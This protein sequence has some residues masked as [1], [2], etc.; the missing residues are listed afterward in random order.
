M[1]YVDVLITTEEDTE[2]VFQIKASEKGKPGEPQ[3]FTEVAAE[4]YREVA[5][6]LEEKFH[7]K[8]VAITLRENPLVWR[9]TWTPIVHAARQFYADLNHDL[10]IRP[11]PSPPPSFPLSFLLS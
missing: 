8:A 6:R 3:K 9:N 7:F 2:V 10:D 5:R 1:Q 4:T 11:P